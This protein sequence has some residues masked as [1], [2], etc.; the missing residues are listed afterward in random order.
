M[1]HKPGLGAIFGIVSEGGIAKD[2]SPVYLMDMRR[3][4]GVG[5]M[6]LL[7][8]QRTRPDG[9]FTFA[10]L[11]P[12][13]DGYAVVATDE[14]GSPEKNA[15]IQD[16]VQ[17]VP[18]HL[19][20]GIE[21]DWYSRI[22][23]DGADAAI[24]PGPVAESKLRPYGLRAM[25][26]L[27][28][29]DATVVFG[30]EEIPYMSMISIPTNGRMETA[31]A[32][33]RA[34]IF[35]NSSIE[36]I[37]DLDSFGG[38]STSLKIEYGLCGDDSHSGATVVSETTRTVYSATKAG[39][40]YVEYSPGGKTLYFKVAENVSSRSW[41]TVSSID[42]SLESGICH[43]IISFKKSEHIKFYINGSLE[44]TA[45]PTY[46]AGS[47][48][49]GGKWAPGIIVGG[50]NEDD[51]GVSCTI[52]PIVSYDI[53]LSDS[54]AE[55]HYKAIFGINDNVALFSGY[56]A[57][58]MKR[59][60]FFYYRLNEA[61]FDDGVSDELH[62]RSPD[63]GVSVAGGV[64]SFSDPAL[65]TGAQDSPLVGM[66]SFQKAS[67]ITLSGA[68]SLCGFPFG[69]AFSFS[70]WVYFDSAAPAQNESLI[71]I[72]T[73]ASYNSS[74]GDRNPR[75]S[76]MLAIE[77]DSSQKKINAKFYI[78]ATYTTVTFNYVPDSGKWLNL[79]IVVELSGA[80]GSASLYAG[81]EDEAPTLKETVALSGGRLHTM[82]DYHQYT[83]IPFDIDGACSIGTGLGGRLIEV[84]LLPRPISEDQIQA[85]WAAKDAI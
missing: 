40:F 78:D 46:Y 64:L 41:T 85:A 58:I 62:F 19:G 56:A 66:A 17:P 67:H 25:T 9:G 36:F 70:C 4:V 83:Y 44:K 34:S 15:L 1:P 82:I 49:A 13:Y 20:A 39:A 35:S 5:Q 11:D 60:P 10:G 51:L 50:T 48:G 27:N 57:E 28:N 69:D 68:S 22:V 72:D 63:T 32:K 2:D 65:V 3:D 8:K 77:R 7:S 38:S 30:P 14:D 75:S 79:W 59:L 16:R 12:D 24:I 33:K 76:G 26:R 31:V 47:S 18:A 81:D 73:F 52:G 45:L 23:R 29:V 80:Y 71:N 43:F 61:V 84:A 6:K 53:A 74:E 42:L 54:Q 37:L 21:G 55:K